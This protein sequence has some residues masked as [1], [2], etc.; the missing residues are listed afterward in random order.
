MSSYEDH[1]TI[2]SNPPIEQLCEQS[3]LKDG[4][5][6]PLKLHEEYT[7]QSSFSGLGDFMSSYRPLWYMRDLSAKFPDVPIRISVRSE[8]NGEITTSYEKI[9]LGGKETSYQYAY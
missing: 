9:F 7:A 6:R 2:K 5:G 4:Y 1:Y 3:G 8:S